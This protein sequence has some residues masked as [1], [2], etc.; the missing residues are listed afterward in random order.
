MSNMR[1]SPIGLRDPCD[2]RDL[3]ARHGA[4]RTWLARARRGQSPSPRRT[5]RASPRFGARKDPGTCPCTFCVP[6]GGASDTAS[7]AFNCRKASVRSTRLEAY[8]AGAPAATPVIASSGNPAVRK[9]A[10]FRIGVAPRRGAVASSAYSPHE[11]A[12]AGCTTRAALAFVTVCYQSETI[13][14]RTGSTLMTA[15]S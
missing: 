15:A 4:D 14:T 3:R 7:R 11:C 1:A 12:L 6:S 9:L 5:T 13:E 8:A 10:R 2:A